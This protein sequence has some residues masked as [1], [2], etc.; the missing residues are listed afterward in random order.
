MMGYWDLWFI[1]GGCCFWN[2]RENK[3]RFWEFYC[4]RFEEQEKLQYYER[5]YSRKHIQKQ[6]P[7]K[8]PK[9]SKKNK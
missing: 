5:F 2:M 8:F 1:F 6:K 7:L 9:N 3:V 4:Q